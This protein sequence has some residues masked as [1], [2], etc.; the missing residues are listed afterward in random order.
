LAASA[1][2]RSLF[3][4]GLGAKSGFRQK[5]NEHLY[6]HLRQNVVMYIVCVAR[7]ARAPVFFDN[8]R[9]WARRPK[10]SKRAP[11]RLALNWSES[12]QKHASSLDAFFAK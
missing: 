2:L 6:L 7:G 5:N 9:P 8:G 12:R 1:S 3:A 11:R 4:P 10:I